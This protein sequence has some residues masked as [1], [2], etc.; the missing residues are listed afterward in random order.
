MPKN[1]HRRNSRAPVPKPTLVV[2]CQECR[3]MQATVNT[4]F[5]FSPSYGMFEEDPPPPCAL[6]K[7]CKKATCFACVKRVS[8]ALDQ[9]GGVIG[10]VC[11]SCLIK[12]KARP[13]DFKSRIHAFQSMK[14]IPK[15][16]EFCTK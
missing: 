6:C 16:I 14:S 15:T 8:F 9:T 10:D 7:L 3:T 2:P 11:P 12:L 5:V 1:R 4:S 13:L